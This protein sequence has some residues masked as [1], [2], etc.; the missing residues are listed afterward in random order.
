MQPDARPATKQLVAHVL[1]V[2]ISRQHQRRPMLVLA[3]GAVH[4]RSCLEQQIEHVAALRF[5]RD[6][7]RLGA[8]TPERMRADHIDHLRR[9]RENSADLV[10][11]PRA[12][13][14]E[15]SFD[16]LIARQRWC[17]GCLAG[18]DRPLLLLDVPLELAPAVEPIIARE[19]PAAPRPGRPTACQR[20]VA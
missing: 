10:D 8:P 15:E 12:N 17:G 16:D 2:L 14:L 7:Q 20:A 11:L 9:R 6:V 4:V 13:Q 18:G 5:D 3:I 1:A 19:L